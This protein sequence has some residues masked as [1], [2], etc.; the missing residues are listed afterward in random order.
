MSKKHNYK[1]RTNEFRDI[2]EYLGKSSWR[3]KENSN[4]NFSHSGMLSHIANKRMANYGLSKLPVRVKK[5]HFNGD[6]HIHN[7]E[8]GNKTGYC[9]GGSLLGLLQKG[10]RS[11]DIQ[12]KPA[13]HFDSILSHI[14]NYFFMSQLEWAGAQAFS[15][16]DTLV[17]PF[18]RHDNLNYK[19]VKQAIQRMVWDL[20]FACRQAFQTPF[21]N[22]T[23]NLGVPKKYQDMPVIIGGKAQSY[24]Y[25]DYQ[26]EIEMINKAFVDVLLER[27]GNGAPLTFPIPTLNLSKNLRWKNNEA[28]D[29]IMEEVSQ[30]G[31]YMFMNY[32]G[33][34]IN[35]DSVR[36]MCCRLNLDLDELSSAR[37][38][39]NMGD[40]TGS[41]GV[42]TINLPRLGF[43][44]RNKSLDEL[45]ERI[46]YLMELAT[47]N[48]KIKR[49]MVQQSIDTG[50]LPFAKFYNINLDHYFNTIGVLGL[51]EMCLNFTN[52]PLSENVDITRKVLEYMR[53]KTKE[54]QEKEGVLFNLE[55]TPA[56]G[57]SYKLALTDVKKYKGIQTLGTKR[58]PYYTALLTP[59]SQQMSVFDRIN[60][61]E[62]LLPLFT[63]GTIFRNYLGDSKPHNGSL[64]SFME[65]LA[66]TK[67][68]YF[69][70]TTTFTICNDEGKMYT[71]K[72]NECPSCASKDID[73][74]SRVVGYYRPIRKYN[75]GKKREFEDRLYIKE[76]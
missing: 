20:N 50:Y 22:L 57:S 10:V 21:T 24:T 55:M 58:Q 67:I 16:F 66:H 38:A 32:V 15:D 33:S 19:Q 65:K 54:L 48:F 7:L 25:S 60:T 49:E 44:Y 5:A 26:E 68:P 63:G 56:E 17:A 1:R 39:W 75:I 73:V 72:H 18:V 74:Y 31:S 8:A 64:K 29:Y 2:E 61:E 40:G 71:G 6:F 4:F 45:L 46:G 62:K 51:N 11:A 27:D 23:F 70:V 42:V 35:E 41:L 37:G 13:K 12:S 59:P 53:N 30:L 36:A 76:I 3:V 52:S 28:L 34:G 43:L 9:H 14:T 69:D 47:K